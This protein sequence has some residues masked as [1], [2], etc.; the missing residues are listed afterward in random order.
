MFVDLQIAFKK[1]LDKWVD[2]KM[3]QM[4]EMDEMNEDDFDL[5]LPYSEDKVP[6]GRFLYY[7]LC[8]SNVLS[9]SKLMIEQCMS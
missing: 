4:D 3:D 5:N 7:R 8:E 9:H 2:K 1:A 6:Y